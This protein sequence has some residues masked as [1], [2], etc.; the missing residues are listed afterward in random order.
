MQRRALHGTETA[1]L[2]LVDQAAAK[3]LFLAFHVRYNPYYMGPGRFVLSGE[4]YAWERV[5]VPFWVFRG[6]FRYQY[7]LEG[8]VNSDWS[9]IP[10]KRIE[11]DEQDEAMQ[12]CATFKYRH[13]FVDVLKGEH[14]W[15]PHR[16]D[17]PREVGSGLLGGS[18]ANETDGGDSL[19]LFE[20][21]NAEVT[22][23]LAWDFVLRNVE[24]KLQR[25]I[26]QLGKDA[27]VRVRVS[28]TPHGSKLVYIPAHVI[29]YTFGEKVDIHNE[30]SKD[31]FYALVSARGG[32][33]ASEG[34]V[35]TRKAAAMG[36]GLAM[37]SMALAS[38]AG[39]ESALGWSGFDY[40]FIGAGSAALW[41]LMA[42]VLRPSSN[43][44]TRPEDSSNHWTDD[45]DA[46]FRLY[47]SEWARW[48]AGSV[49][50]EVDPE[51]RRRWA[52]SIIRGHRNRMMRLHA[53]LEERAALERIELERE[54][55]RERRSRR[56][57]PD[58]NRSSI[59]RDQDYLGYYAA[60]GFES[61]EDYAQI[62]RHDIKKAFIHK[63]RTLHPDRRNGVDGHERASESWLM[64]V[65]AYDVLRDP[66]KRKKYD[67][68]EAT[69]ASS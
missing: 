56:W 3:N 30:R 21:D 57:G 31:R 17:P 67:N 24:Q 60:L 15:D 43:N 26:S 44:I 23:G 50:F 37:G 2:V 5:C 4:E 38:I 54:Q 9:S 36:G 32:R 20:M 63:V 12:V 41:A 52:E 11:L 1:G 35:S 7:K 34:H 8:D 16:K 13:D 29:R 39:Y 64:V 28:G 61:M 66:E 55:R 68:G 65:E 25:Q 40:G 59:M 18:R 42:Q 22:R 62:S 33:V 27:E 46:L 53:T 69:R 49:G 10:E 14:V 45:W 51:K 58:Q 47:K 19:D 6:A 48:S